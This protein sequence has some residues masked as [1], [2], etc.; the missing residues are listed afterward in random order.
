MEYANI[1]FKNSNRLIYTNETGKFTIEPISDNDTL[2]IECIGYVSKEIPL[3][4]QSNELVIEL[5][6]NTE[7]LEEVVISIN[8]NEKSK[9]RK[10]NRRTRRYDQTYQGLPEG[11]ILISSYKIDEELKINGIR[12]FI[13]VNTLNPDGSLNKKFKKIIRPIL[14]INSINLDNNILPNKIIY[15]KKD[16]D[17]FTK[18]DIEFA[19]TLHLQSGETLT[20]GLELIPENLEKPN[21]DNVLGILTTKHLLKESK[22]YL[23]NLFSKKQGI[24]HDKP[25]NEDIYFELKIVK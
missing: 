2:I 1:R 13:M 9:W 20:I 3:K 17:L 10:I 6:Q 24:L 7:L 14:I 4:K 21:N 22:T 12:L 23:T 11:F 15:L 16:V 5:E 19:N 25:L 8:N 18:L